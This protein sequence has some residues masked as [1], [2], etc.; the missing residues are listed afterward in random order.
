MANISISDL[1]STG[2]ELF[3]DPENYRIIFNCIKLRH[4]L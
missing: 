2:S 1:R 3:V 4:I